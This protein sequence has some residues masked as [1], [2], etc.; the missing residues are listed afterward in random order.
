MNH[1]LHVLSSDVGLA[2]VE[3]KA[4][5]FLLADVEDLDFDVLGPA[6]VADV[7]RVAE[8]VGLG[9]FAIEGDFGERSV[10]FEADNAVF[11]V[12]P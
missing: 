4:F 2:F 3:L 10:C 9:I 8:L 6:E 1:P 12:L 5:D 11:G 7:V